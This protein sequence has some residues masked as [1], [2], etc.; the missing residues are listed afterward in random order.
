MNE[1]SQT[2]LRKIKK[3]DGRWKRLIEWNKSQ[4]ENDHSSDNSNDRIWDKGFAQLVELHTHLQFALICVSFYF[5]YCFF[6]K[7]ADRVH[8]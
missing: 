2:A 7:S 6:K 4:R 1:I 5:T 3:E 8:N